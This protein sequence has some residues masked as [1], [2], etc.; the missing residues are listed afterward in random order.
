MPTPVSGGPDRRRLA[1]EVALRPPRTQIGPR[2]PSADPRGPGT[3]QGCRSPSAPTGWSGRPGLASRRL[4]R[5]EPGR[6]C[7]GSPAPPPE[8]SA[9]LAPGLR[10]AAAGLGPL[11]GRARIPSPQRRPGP[12]ASRRPAHSRV[13]A[14][15]D[16][17]RPVVHLQADRAAVL[18][19]Q[20]AVT[21]RRPARRL[22]LLSRSHQAAEHRH[23]GAR[24]AAAAAPVPARPGQLG[25]SRPRR[26]RADVIRAAPRPGPLVK[27]AAPRCW[28]LQRALRPQPAERS[29]D[30]VPVTS[31][32]RVSSPP[33]LTTVGPSAAMCQ[34]GED[35][36]DPAPE[37][38]PP[39]RP[40]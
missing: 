33:P 10:P 11:P 37:G 23:P 31:S 12:A 36:G 21:A 29:P 9:R 27:T 13:A 15:A 8:P 26:R 22:P 25:A 4:G 7:A 6:R 1:Q 5:G 3:G 30:G 34:V 19:L 39:P 2:K 17:H 28:R 40:G 24:P 20:A 16:G 35:Y 18:R 32:G 38:P 14:A